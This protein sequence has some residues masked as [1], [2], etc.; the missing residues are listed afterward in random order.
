MYFDDRLANTI[1]AH[2]PVFAYIH[3][4]VFSCASIALDG[5][6]FYLLSSGRGMIPQYILLALVFA[7][8]YLT[9]I[10]DGAIA[11]TYSKVSV[12]G[13]LLDTAGDA[14]L[15]LIVIWYICALCGLPRMCVGYAAVAMIAF[16]MYEGTVHDHAAYKLYG[17]D[18]V[19]DILAWCI[20][21]TVWIF[22]ALYVF[23][24]MTL[25]RCHVIATHFEGCELRS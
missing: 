19:R 3:P 7:A 25:P 12:L 6:I 15:M 1:V 10:L 2:T 22:A 20:N 8:R 5:L 23:I 11:R 21:N 14:L 9:D 18:R 24:V 17:R 16:M 4:N 13:G